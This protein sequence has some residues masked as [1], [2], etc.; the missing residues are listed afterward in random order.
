MQCY[1]T[2]FKVP[3]TYLVKTEMAQE[4]IPLRKTW[5]LFPTK[6]RFKNALFRPKWRFWSSRNW[7][8]NN[9]PWKPS[10]AKKTLGS[11]FFQLCLRSLCRFSR[12][13][14]SQFRKTRRY[15]SRNPE[16]SANSLGTSP[17]QTYTVTQR[18]LRIELWMSITWLLEVTSMLHPKPV[19]L[20]LWGNLKQCIASSCIW[21]Q[22]Y[23]WQ[24]PRTKIL[25]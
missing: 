23:R 11:I 12:S 3:R 8:K 18:S 2:G 4:K 19:S 6:R 9:S 21:R 13:T 24:C 5:V 22:K 15:L 14:R 17:F 10:K 7:V 20:R 16:H 25:V 1:S